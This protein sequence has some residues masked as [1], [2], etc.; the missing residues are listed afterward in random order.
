MR[1]VKVDCRLGN[2]KHLRG[3]DILAKK[4]Q[5]YETPRALQAQ[6]A[7]SAEVLG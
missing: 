6:R 2:V 1:G 5:T 3:G 4:I 7:V